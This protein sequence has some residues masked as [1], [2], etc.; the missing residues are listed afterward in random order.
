MLIIPIRTETTIRRTPWV[1]YGLIAANVLVYLIFDWA[2]LS[3]AAGL[4]RYL[5]LEAGWPHV[6]QFI[7]YQF[8]HGDLMHLL[9]NMLFLFVFGNSV[10]AK[11][12]HL[13][14]LFFYLAGGVFAALGYAL[15]STASLLGASGSIAAVTT[16]YLALFPRSRVTVL[17][18]LF[19]FV[20][21]F[22]LPAI[23]IIGLK[24]ILWDNIVAPS[25]G[26][27]PANVA[28]AAH[29]AGYGFGFGATMLMLLAR[30]LPRD[31]FDVLALWSRWRR[32]QVF[33][34]VMSDPQAQAQARYGRVARPIPAP[35]FQTP[36]ARRAEEQR[37]DQILDLR[38]Q[39]AGHLE[40]REVQ[41]AATLYEQLLTSDPRQCL[42]ERHQLE[43]ARA[44]YDSGRFPQ[45]IAAFER[46]LA[47]YPDS[48]DADEIRLLV[49]IIYARDL[50]Q[51]GLAEKFLSAVM[52][53]FA[54]GPRRDQAER[55]LRD[56]R[57][58]MGGA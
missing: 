18:W 7:T 47:C 17:M 38:S 50:G 36:D 35:D 3:E 43:L 46:Y 39:I 34:S 41:A 49:G 15:G 24:I 53:R 33:A 30:G 12:G 51:F 29:L 52:G 11:M 37:H 27:G 4:K 19:V 10:N 28:Y 42:P 58:A 31:Q 57:A 14:Y 8:A 54:E 13:P 48:P 56:V 5:V 55:W 32:R 6:Y 45:A 20:Q 9:G 1:N 44:F 25:I 26:S 23:V 40:R 16:A 22:E 21:T 2:P